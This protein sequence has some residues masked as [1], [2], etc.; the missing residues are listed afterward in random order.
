M[1]HITPSQNPDDEEKP[2]STS[3]PTLP[4]LYTVLLDLFLILL[5]DSVYNSRSRV[6]FSRVASFL[7]LSPLD[8]LKL[9]RRITEALDVEEDIEKIDTVNIVE[10]V[11]KRNKT[12]RYVMLGLATL[13]G[14]LVIGLSAGLLAPAIGA[15]LGAALGTIEITGTT[16]FLAGTCGAAV[17]TTGGILTGS[18]IGLKGMITR[19]TQVTTFEVL[20]ARRVS[21]IV[22][23]PGFLNG[24]HDDPPLPFSVL[25]PIIRDVYSILWE[26][27]MI[28]ETGSALK[29]L[30]GEV[31]FSNWTNRFAGYCH[32]RIDVRTSMANYP[33]KTRISH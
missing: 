8:T 11:K 25:D 5:A 27:E 1:V 28:R 15:G 21:A 14:G 18:G 17:I 32:D 29:I 10:D 7:S 2:H 19:T 31:L 13:G 20:N 6:L 30:T 12:K 23:V 26:P 16:P 33:H 9:E 3:V 22:T 4:T 24:M